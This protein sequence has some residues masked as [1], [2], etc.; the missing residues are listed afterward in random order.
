M[1][2]LIIVISLVFIAIIAVSYFYFS[3]L[4]EREPAQPPEIAP[5]EVGAVPAEP[6]AAEN[7]ILW[8][9]DLNASAITSPSI[10]RNGDSTRFILVQ[11]A[12]HIL[13]AISPEGQK[14]WNAQLPGPLVDSISQLTDG[15]LVFTTAERLYRI[16][17]EGDPLPGFSLKLPQRATQG[18]VAKADGTVRID[19]GTRRQVL[20]YD[21]RG[22]LLRRQARSRRSSSDEVDPADQ[23]TASLPHGCGPIAY[24]GPL[25]GSGQRYLLCGKDGKLYCFRY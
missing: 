21:G 16:D 3:N 8:T 13:H 6:P 1:R 5:D 4:D 7:G 25:N 15:S 23:P 10:H 22:R 18:A 11:D 9:F 24:V 19:V 2:N 12:Y 17:T 14:L 20:S